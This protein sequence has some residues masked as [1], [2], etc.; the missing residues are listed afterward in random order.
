MTYNETSCPVEAL[1]ETLAPISCGVVPH[2]VIFSLGALQMA[3]IVDFFHV[4]VSCKLIEGILD[5]CTYN[6]PRSNGLLEH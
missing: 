3:I 4:F 6:L 1:L 5:R 2:Q